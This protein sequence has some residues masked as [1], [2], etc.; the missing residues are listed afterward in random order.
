MRRKRLN[1]ST[2]LG[3]GTNRKKSPL[4]LVVS[5]GLVGLAIF[6]TFSALFTEVERDNLTLCRLDRAFPR[7]TALLLDTTG[8]YSR[9]QALSI[10]S[11]LNEVQSYLDDVEV[12]IFY[13]QRPKL[14]AI[15]NRSHI[16]Q[17]WRPLVNSSGGRIVS[18]QRINLQ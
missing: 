16:E 18:V 4:F 10:A 3:R 11:Y 1:Q 17:F 2:K 5:L 8:G 14:L 6:Y 15:Q 13:I 9:A 12:E 7:E